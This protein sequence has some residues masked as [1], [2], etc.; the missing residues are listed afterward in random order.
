MKLLLINILSILYSSYSFNRYTYHTKKHYQ[1]LL[2]MNQFTNSMKQLFN[3]NN[4]DNNDD[5]GSYQLNINYFNEN[6]K[7][8]NIKTWKEIEEQLLNIESKEER[9]EYELKLKGFIYIIIR[10]FFYISILY[11]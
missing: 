7:H 11:T 5:S 10:Y 6:N 4:N 1:K 9:N 8:I 3:L 2:H